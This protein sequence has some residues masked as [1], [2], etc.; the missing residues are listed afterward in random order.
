MRAQHPFKFEFGPAEV[1]EVEEGLR[2]L[3]TEDGLEF[4]VIIS[5]QMQLADYGV[6]GSPRWWEAT[7]YEVEEI[8]YAGNRYT[9]DDFA[10][11]FGIHAATTVCKLAF[12]H[13]ETFNDWSPE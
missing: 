2:P 3:F 9:E 12:E 8:E 10:R 5:T 6:R 13:A 7:D 11:L 4:T 1:S